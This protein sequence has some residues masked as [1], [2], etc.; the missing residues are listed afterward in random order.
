MEEGISMHQ[1]ETSYRVLLHNWAASEPRQLSHGLYKVSPDIVSSNTLFEQSY[2][3]RLWYDLLGGCNASNWIDKVLF[4]LL[5]ATERRL[6]WNKNFPAKCCGHLISYNN[7]NSFGTSVIAFKKWINVL[8]LIYDQNGRKRTI[9]ELHRTINASSFSF[10]SNANFLSK[11]TENLWRES[12]SSL[13]T[14][15][16]SSIARSQITK[17]E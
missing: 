1:S 7:W 9:S 5:T 3:G 10:T 8:D 14:S 11:N 15:A 17:E 12:L 2:S 6:G 4:I 13:I 16:T